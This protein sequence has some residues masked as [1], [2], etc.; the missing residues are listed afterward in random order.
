LSPVAQ[1]GAEM[2]NSELELAVKTSPGDLRG[3]Q[4]LIERD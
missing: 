3:F 4:K 1:L 2:K